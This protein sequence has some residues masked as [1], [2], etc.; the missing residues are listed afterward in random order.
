MIASANYPYERRD[1][2]IDT[3]AKVDIETYPVLLDHI[4]H[5][6]HR[7]VDVVAREVEQDAQ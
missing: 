1:Q 7:G 4:F 3:V 6:L 5:L 2:R